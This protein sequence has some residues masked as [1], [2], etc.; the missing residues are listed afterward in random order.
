MKKAFMS[1]EPTFILNSPL[2]IYEESGEASALKG[3]D[4]ASTWI[5]KKAKSSL[6]TWKKKCVKMKTNAEYPVSWVKYKPWHD[7]LLHQPLLQV[8]AIN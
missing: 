4:L 7:C 6:A 3:F 1:K 8:G 2:R 5:A